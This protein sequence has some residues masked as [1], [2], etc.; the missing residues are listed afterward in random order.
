MAERGAVTWDAEQADG[1]DLALRARGSSARRSAGGALCPG[2]PDGEGPRRVWP[3][4]DE[5]VPASTRSRATHTSC[6]TG[7]RLT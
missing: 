5:V 2:G 3:F 6:Q 4:Q 7:V 1:S